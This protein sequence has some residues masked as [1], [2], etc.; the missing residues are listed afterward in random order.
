MTTETNEGRA[1][2]ALKPRRNA[3][4]MGLTFD[5]A[6]VA[7]A[8]PAPLAPAQFAPQA[9]PQLPYDKPVHYSSLAHVAS[10]DPNT[11]AP[12][13]EPQGHAHAHAMQ[14]P[15]QAHRVVPRPDTSVHFRLPAARRTALF[16][17]ARLTGTTVQALMSEAVDKILEK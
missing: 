4:R 13:G 12:S 7:A 11:G 8:H 2:V 16:V 9:A 1:T 17:H 6:A 3:P 14:Q 15:S 10:V 5:A